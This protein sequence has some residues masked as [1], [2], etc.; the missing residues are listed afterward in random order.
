[1][2]VG[3]L[4]VIYL[5]F[6]YHSFP[7]LFLAKRKGKTISLSRIVVWC[8]C[9]AVKLT[10]TQTTKAPGAGRLQ[11]GVRSLFLFPGKHA[12]IHTLDCTTWR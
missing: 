9:H 2:K 10:K 8:R 7:F 6:P 12:S 3:I 4:P 11:Q 1:M 5:C